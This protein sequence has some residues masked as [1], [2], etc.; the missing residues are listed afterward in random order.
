M[1]FGFIDKKNLKNVLALKTLFF[2][3]YFL[4]LIEYIENKSELGKLNFQLHWEFSPMIFS[5]LFHDNQNIS[6]GIY[7]L[8]YPVYK[9]SK[10]IRSPLRLWIAR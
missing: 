5:I 9:V 4:F 7:L 3:F 2:I 6:R 10:G 8:E 1:L